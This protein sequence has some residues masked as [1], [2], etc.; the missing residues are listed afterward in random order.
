MVKE[1]LFG[2]ME[3]R[4]REN[5]RMR[6]KCQ[7]ILTSPDGSQCGGDWRDNKPWNIIEFDNEQH[8]IGMW[9]NGIEE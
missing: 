9:L 2:L 8:I 5:S 6:K 4:M 7:G 3:I 1:H